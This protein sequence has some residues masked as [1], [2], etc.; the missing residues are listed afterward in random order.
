MEESC[1]PYQ[2]QTKANQCRSYEKCS[3][4]AKI[5]KSYFL[6]DTQEV[7]I[8]ENKIMK[9]IMRNGPVVGEFKAPNKFRYYDK[10]ILI[11]EDK[12]ALSPS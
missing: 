3:P 4:V 6:Q 12:P 8:D 11:D 10:G 5:N 1:A 7:Q 2:G 9:E